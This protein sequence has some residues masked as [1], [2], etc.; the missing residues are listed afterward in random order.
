MSLERNLKNYLLSIYNPKNK[1]GNVFLF[2]IGLSIHW[3]C[4][5]IL[6]PFVCLIS[7]QKDFSFGTIGS[8]VE[9]EWHCIGLRT[10]LSL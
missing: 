10:R 3:D 5:K 7:N 1:L 8:I 4:W 9:V 2:C 6:L